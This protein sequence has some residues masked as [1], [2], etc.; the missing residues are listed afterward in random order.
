VEVCPNRG[1]QAGA[2]HPWEL[3]PLRDGF[4]WFPEI[5]HAPIWAL[6][7]TRKTFRHIAGLDDGDGGPAGERKQGKSKAANVPVLIYASRRVSSKRHV[8]GERFLLQDLKQR[9]DGR[10]KIKVVGL[11]GS[12]IIDPSKVSKQWGGANMIIAPH[13]GALANLLYCRR[14]TGV[15][16]FATLDGTGSPA[17]A[18]SYFG[19]LAEVLGLPYTL[20]GEPHISEADQATIYQN[21]TFADDEMRRE[22]AVEGI[23]AWING[24]LTT[25]NSRKDQ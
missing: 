5:F 15:L 12:Q 6:H 25:Q 19:Y 23:M 3:E 16:V 8:E 7:L 18:E 20:L 10:V 1:P 24:Q 4:D 17:V 22:K 11:E 13:G 2:G 21:Y 14:G 9:L